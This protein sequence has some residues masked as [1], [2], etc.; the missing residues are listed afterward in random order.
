MPS[1]AYTALD[2]KDAF[3]KGRVQARHQRAA[4]RKLEGEGFTV[5]SVKREFIETWYN[6]PLWQPV[7]LE[8]RIFFTRNLQTLVAAGIGLDQAVHISSEQT[9][10]QRFRPI[11]ADIAKRLRQGQS[12]HSTLQRYPNVFSTFFINLVRVG[13]SSGKLDETLE[14][15]LV[16]QERD[17]DLRSKA[18]GAMIYPLIIL[19]ALLVMVTLMLTFV[20]PKVA[21]VLNQYKVE[22]PLTTRILLALS[23]FL[24]HYGL[25]LLPIIVVLAFLGRQWSRTKRG[26]WFLDGLVLRLP[27]IRRVVIE[28]NLARFGRSLSSLLKSGIAINQ[29]LALSTTVTGNIRYQ[30]AIERGIPLIEKGLPLHEVLVAQP[31]LY[32]PLVTRMVEVGERSGKLEEMTDRIAHFYEK[33]VTGLLENLSSTLEPLLLILVGAAVGFIAVS[34]LT[35]VW[36]FSATI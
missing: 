28:F 30:T 14:Y 5:V 3:V 11:L 13:E 24:V 29:A 19:G 36:R 34:V 32:P 17:Y 27:I 21:S 1:Y 18:R 22:L 4:T 2:S 20:I 26:R 25:Y 16:Q 33:S 9:T 35:P 8:D 7:S 15:L 23:N 31:Q 12:F 10:N 6:R